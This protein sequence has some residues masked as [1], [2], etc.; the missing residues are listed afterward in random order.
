MPPYMPILSK[1]KMATA[2]RLRNFKVPFR[3]LVS[4]TLCR[5]ES[6]QSNRS[7]PSFDSKEVR[8]ILKKISGRNLD[9]IFIARKQE[10][11]VPSYKLMTD[12]EFL[13]VRLSHRLQSELILVYL[14]SG[15]VT[16]P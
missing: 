9:K 1:T 8:S 4:R 16:A 3:L 13:K 5:H 15:K 11:G 6:S 14:I 10:R 12:A 2:C 7:I